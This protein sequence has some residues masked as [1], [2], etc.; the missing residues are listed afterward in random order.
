VGQLFMGGVQV[1]RTPAFVSS[2]LG[3]VHVGA[4]LLVG[5]ATTGTRGVAT[6]A[7]RARTVAGVPAGVHAIVAADQEGGLVQHL[8]GPGFEPIP[9]ASEQAQLTPSQLR[10]HAEAWGEDLRAASVDLDLA[11]VADVVPA[12]VG[13]A[14]MPI[15]ALHRGYGSDPSSVGQHVAAFVSGMGQAGVA[16]AVKHFPGLGKVRGNTDFSAGVVDRVTTRDD[17]DLAP[18]GAGIEAGA[19]FLMVSLATY[20]KIDPDHRAVFSEP[21]IDGMV[22]KD[23]G[24]DGVVLSDDLGAA[25]EVEAVPPAQR[26]LRFLRAGGDVIVTVEASIL[27]AMTQA[28]IAA[29]KSSRS[30]RSAID[31]HV[32]RVLTAKRAMGLL[33]CP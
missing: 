25:A 18:F 6:A 27:P 8:K 31:H 17:P 9:T 30:F 23:L 14:N 11:P 1:D 3:A 10:T 2:T 16:T 12:S 4:I 20:S 15:G 26:A 24:F 7:N 5:Q 21:V 28:V 19:G 13:T 22:R 32:L 33:T 29:A